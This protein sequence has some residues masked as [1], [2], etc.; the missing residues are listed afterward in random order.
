MPGLVFQSVVI[1]G[2]YATGREL[3]E[4]FAHAGPTGGLLGMAVTT[5]IWSAVLAVSFELVR[6]TQSY[7]YKSFFTVLLGRGWFVFEIA[8]FLLLVLVLSVLGAASGEIVGVA[9]GAPKLAG[10][11]A[12]MALVAV[13]V[14]FGGKIIE[15]A[16]GWSAIALFAVFIGLI[17]WSLSVFGERI[18]GNFA[19]VPVQSHWF[20]SG[21][22]YSAYN[23]A[24]VVATFF[25]IRHLTRR[26]EAIV[27]G[28]LGGP[29]TMLPGMLFYISMMGYYPEINS[30]PVPS[31]FL[32][33]KLGAPWF[34]VVFQVA[35]LWTLVATGVGMIHAI[36][37][38]VA[39]L[40]Q[41]RGRAMPRQ[42]RP[43]IALAILAVSVFV[44]D[45]VGIIGLIAKGYGLLTWVF[46]AVLVLPVLTIGIW[47]LRRLGAE[48]VTR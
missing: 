11:L 43:A 37:E 19:A 39:R 36:N 3:I 12:M 42:L 6:R 46:I 27:A 31:I 1:G 47:K 24:S 40:Y 7:D 25:C 38:R 30:A 20:M 44:A 26:R 16:L 10:T 41:E 8:Y 14:F 18:S 9:T 33:G 13:L 35:V 34:N 45:A 29:L 22:T 28:L 32:V 21:V 2:G 15:R 48:V 5:L 23:M 4:F 17:F